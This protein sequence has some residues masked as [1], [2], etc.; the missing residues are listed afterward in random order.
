MVDRRQLFA[1]TVALVAAAKLASADDKKKPD[2]RTALL[3][4]LGA[5]ETKG[6]PCAAHCLAQLGTGAK[7]FAHCASAVADALAVTAATAG[8]V[9]RSSPNAKKAVELCLATC[10]ECS[11]ACLEHQ[12]HWAHGMHLEC[13]ACMEACDACIKACQAYLAA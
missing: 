4:A 13:K 5:C 12:A 3:E 8:L 1:G 9:A 11:A 2:T 10:K 7:E 6:A